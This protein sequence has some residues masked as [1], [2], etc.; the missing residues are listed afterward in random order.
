VSTVVVKMLVVDVTVWSVLGTVT[1]AVVGIST[2]RVTVVGGKGSCFN[3]SKNSI[4]SNYPLTM[5]G[6][7]FL[8]WWVI[9]ERQ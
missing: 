3:Q 2:V 8:C 1:I 5:T 4:V 6:T 7:I 9:S